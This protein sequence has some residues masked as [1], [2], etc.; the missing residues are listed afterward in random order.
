MMSFINLIRC[1]FIITYISIRHQKYSEQYFFIEQRSNSKYMYKM[2]RCHFLFAPNSFS[3]R[4]EN[5][6][7]FYL[8]S[9]SILVLGLSLFLSMRCAWRV[10]VEVCVGIAIA[11]G[12]PWPSTASGRAAERRPYRHRRRLPRLQPPRTS[13]VRL[14]Q[15]QPTYSFFDQPR[16]AL[17][18]S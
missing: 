7:H 11:R 16:Q 17:V 2:S 15:K 8:A 10:I 1:N 12:Q 14:R 3:S 6:F 13:N 18:F 9:R 4:E 5:C